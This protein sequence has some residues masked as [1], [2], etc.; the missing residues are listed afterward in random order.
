MTWGFTTVVGIVPSRLVTFG[1]RP[2][3]GATF[4]TG[5]DPID[6]AAVEPPPMLL[7]LSFEHE[8]TFFPPSCGD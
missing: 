8:M 2:E 1:E 6:D 3:L 5:L 4:V 7:L